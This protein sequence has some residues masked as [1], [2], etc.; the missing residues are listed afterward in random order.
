MIPAKAAVFL[1]RRILVYAEDGHKGA[2]IM[3]KVHGAACNCGFGPLEDALHDFIGHG[4]KREWQAAL[5]AME[6][7]ADTEGGDA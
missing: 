7:A 4:R 6:A 1:A 3:F 5:D 2:C